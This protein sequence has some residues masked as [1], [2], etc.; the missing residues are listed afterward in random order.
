MVWILKLK[1]NIIEETE[2][3]GYE[4]NTTPPIDQN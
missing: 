4:R 2:G 3:V 1:T